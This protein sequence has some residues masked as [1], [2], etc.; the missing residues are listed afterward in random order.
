MDEIPEGATIEEY[1]DGKA[2]MIR[3]KNGKFLPGSKPI[4]TIHTSDEGKQ[5]VKRRHQKAQ[6][7]ALQAMNNVAN[8]ANIIIPEEIPVDYVGWYAINNDITTS[9][10]VNDNLRNKV[11]AAK[12][13][14]SNT[15]MIQ[16]QD[17][18]QSGDITISSDMRQLLHDI[19]VIIEESK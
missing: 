10:F 8:Q 17:T 16:K 1:N 11:E 9:L 15:G 4:S 14:G 19:A 3:G 2:I 13:L 7:I 12:F 6:E 5:L 18:E